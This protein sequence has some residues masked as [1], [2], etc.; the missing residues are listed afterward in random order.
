MVHPPCSAFRSRRSPDLLLTV[1]TDPSLSRRVTRVRVTAT[2]GDSR[3]HRSFV[4]TGG[5]AFEELSKRADSRQAYRG[6]AIGCSRA[7]KAA[8]SA[9]ATGRA[10]NVWRPATASQDWP[11]FSTAEASPIPVTAVA[12]A[13]S[14]SGDSEASLSISARHRSSKSGSRSSSSAS[15]T[16]TPFSTSAV[17]TCS[18]STFDGSA[19]E[20]GSD[21]R[22]EK[23]SGTGR[24]STTR[25]ANLGVKG[26]KYPRSHIAASPRPPTTSPSSGPLHR[27][28]RRR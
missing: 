1:R 23:T 8:T 20:A 5:T 21:G 25:G 22:P 28:R 24:E 7:R 14:V 16:S 26:T 9:T 3:R 27:R 2:A 17:T 10:I 15:G 19:K 13:A 11:L 12:S 4:R 6:S 18:P